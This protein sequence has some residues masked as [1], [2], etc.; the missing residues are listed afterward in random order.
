L[1]IPVVAPLR[2][3]DA[4][5]ARGG[6]SIVSIDCAAWRL[7]VHLYSIERCRWSSLTRPTSG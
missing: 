7:P 6:S 4:T 3:H 5:L 2:L 1:G